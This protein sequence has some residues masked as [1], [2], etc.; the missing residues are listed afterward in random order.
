MRAKA[1]G[2]RAAEQHQ[3]SPEEYAQGEVQRGI[4]DT[5]VRTADTAQTTTRMSYRKFCALQEKRKTLTAQSSTA[6]V[7]KPTEK[8]KVTVLTQ[9][10]R[11]ERFKKS[12][13]CT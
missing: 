9:A 4:S 8:E 12:F 10:E 7:P 3:E 1:Q 6:T 13:D 2:E 5:A 11:R